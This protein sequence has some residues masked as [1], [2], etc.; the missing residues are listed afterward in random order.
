MLFYDQKATKKVYFGK[1]KKDFIVLKP[2]SSLFV[3]QQEI[4]TV[5]INEECIDHVEEVPV[6]DGETEKRI[7]YHPGKRAEMVTRCKEL[8]Y[9]KIL[10]SIESWSH[11]EEPTLEQ[12]KKLTPGVRIQLLV[13]IAQLNSLSEDEIKN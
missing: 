1:N 8:D 2:L 3:D 5:R 11:P 4:E 13:E 9:Q 10:A 7:I 12:V 6:K